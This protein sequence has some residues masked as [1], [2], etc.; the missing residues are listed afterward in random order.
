MLYYQC[1]QSH[2][3]FSLV[4]ICRKSPDSLNFLFTYE[5]IGRTGCSFIGIHY[6]YA[7]Q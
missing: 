2:D 7:F 3:C 6:T 1:K 5:Q 4:E